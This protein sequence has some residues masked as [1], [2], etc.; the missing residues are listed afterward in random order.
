MRIAVLADTGLVNTYYRAFTVAELVDRGHGVLLG[1]SDAIDRTELRRGFDAVFL[2]RY[3]DAG[4]LAFARDMSALGLAVVWDND[5]HVTAVPESSGVA[6][7]KGALRAQRQINELRRMIG[8]VDLVTTPS[9]PLAEVYREWGAAHVEV[10]ENYLPKRFTAPVAARRDDELVIGWTAAKEH[11]HEVQR[12]GLGELFGR[13]LD[14]HPQLRVRTIGVDL[15]LRH[16]RYERL[17]LVQYPNLGGEI[18]RFDVGIAPLDDIEFNRARSNVKVKEYAFAGVP[19]LASPVAPYAAL[20]EKQG[21]RLVAD[22][23][24]EQELERLIGKE[25]D[26]RKLAKRARNWGRGE[27][28]ANNL[29][30]WERALEGAVARVRAR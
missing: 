18:A 9:A 13:L 15:G 5:D 3:S 28:A 7:A 12:F 25:R 27:T 6:N 17:A 22:D 10:V 1:R 8:A 23:A 21:G 30:R 19:W 11:V 2:Y 20:G 29:E 26:R 16:D 14:R 4:A 24:W